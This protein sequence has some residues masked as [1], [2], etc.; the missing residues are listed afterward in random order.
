MGVHYD[1]KGKYFTDIV[2]K[3]ALKV[4]IGTLEHQIHGEI[5]LHQGERLIDELN[6]GERFIAITNAQVLD[7]QGEIL[8][9]TNFM[10][11]NRKHLVWIIPDRETQS[12]R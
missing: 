2:A 5:H 7:K 12:N 1:N 4:V 8:Y 9:R 6:N 10:I 3:D 11:L